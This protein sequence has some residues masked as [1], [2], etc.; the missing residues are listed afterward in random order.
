M[1]DSFVNLW[2]VWGGLGTLGY[3]VMVCLVMLATATKYH[4]SGVIVCLAMLLLPNVRIIQYTV[5]Y[6]GSKIV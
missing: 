4:S 5:I 1:A 3:G 6:L 2:L